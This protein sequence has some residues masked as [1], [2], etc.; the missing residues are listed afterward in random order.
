MNYAQWK[1]LAELREELAKVDK[2]LN[3]KRSGTPLTFDDNNLYINDKE[4]P[5]IG[6]ICMDMLFVKIDDNVYYVKDNI[7]VSSEKE[8]VKEKIKYVRTSVTVY[9]NEKDSKITSFICVKYST[10]CDFYK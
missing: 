3:I 5:I 6:N 2:S 4:Y 1:N 7:L 8:V 10:R 9:K